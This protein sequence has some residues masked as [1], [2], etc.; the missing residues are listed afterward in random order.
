MAKL[1]QPMRFR[2][3]MILAVDERGLIFAVRPRLIS[4]G[5]A[6]ELG[7]TVRLQHRLGRDQRMLN[8][9][10]GHVSVQRFGQVAALKEAKTARHRSGKYGAG[11]ELIHM[12]TTD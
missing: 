6:P 1:G 9:E 11:N 7:L 4:R 8:H 5:G 2:E 12:R 3:P 10:V